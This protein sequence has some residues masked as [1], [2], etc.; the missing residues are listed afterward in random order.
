MAFRLLCFGAKYRSELAF[1]VDA[2]RAGA[3]Q[4]GLLRGVCPRCSRDKPPRGADSEWAQAYFDRFQEAIN[5]DLNTP[6]ALAVVLDLVG[7][8][9]RRNDKR[10]LEHA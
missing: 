5:N 4:S 2:V 1:S 7:E 10:D 3:E 8:A 6:Q 9:Y